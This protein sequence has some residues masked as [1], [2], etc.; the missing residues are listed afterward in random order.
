MEGKPQG[1]EVIVRTERIA[2]AFGSLWA[3][4]GVD[5]KVRAG[6]CYGL[7]GPNGSGKTTLIR[8]IAGLL[9]R[10]RHRPNIRAR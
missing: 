2:R 8:M 1:E 3:V 5:L 9:R 4:K 6:E 7:L 10:G